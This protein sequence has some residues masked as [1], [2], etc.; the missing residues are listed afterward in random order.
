[1]AYFSE[2][3]TDSTWQP[4]FPAPPYN[5]TLCPRLHSFLLAQRQKEPTW[6]NAPVPAFFPALGP[7][8]TRLLIVG[9]APGLSG[10]NRT[11]RAFTGDYAGI[12][13]YKTLERFG[14]SRG[15]FAAMAD[16]GV[17]LI[18]T[19]IVNAVRCVPPQNKP[20]G[21]EIKHC[22][23]FLTPL[24]LKLPRLC[25]VISLGSVAHNST[26]RALE[27]R[28]SAYPFGHHK[29]Y[30]IGKLRLFSSYHCSRYNTNTGVLTEAMFHALFKDVRHYLDEI[31]QRH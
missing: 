1:M 10:A 15:A 17:S 19:A 23:R 28:P 20:L 25:A 21:D 3:S 5:C 26:L 12:L 8:S 7:L 2:N 22:R 11:G 30:D 24:L 6:H 9:L 29:V 31:S 14:F 4:D 13:L 16:D 18:E 27:A